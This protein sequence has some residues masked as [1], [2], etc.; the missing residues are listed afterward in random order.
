MSEATAEL[1]RFDGEVGAAMAPFE[2]LLLRSEAAASSQIEDLTASAK[3]IALAEIGEGRS[4]A[5]ADVIVANTRAMQA[6]LRLADAPDERS[7]IEVHR[8]LLEPSAPDAVGRWREQAV[9]IGGVSSSPH[10]AA[11]VAPEWT[12]I[13]TAMEDLVRFMG[14]HDV[15]PLMLIAIAHAQFETIHPFPD[16][17]GRT[18]RALVHALL[19]AKRV[20]TTVT[21]PV[22][23][24]LLTDTDRYFDALT[25]YRLGEPQ[26]IVEMLS[27]SSFEAVNNGRALVHDLRATRAEWDEL[28]TARRG[29]TAHRLADLLMRQPVVTSAIVQQELQVAPSNANLALEHLAN[30]GILRQV[31]TGRRNRVWAAS[32]VLSALDAFA[33]RAG[34]RNRST[35]RLGR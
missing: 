27:T 4:R 21:V 18:G 19:R 32:D 23:A 3:A 9:W 7:I 34:R 26:P 11:Y 25:A 29:A 2:A 35:T 13:P 5:N 12:R 8:A 6:A 15:P 16:G 31:S 1:A 28:I 22:S 20:T 30:E 14:R 17:N 33:Q 10:G 24:G